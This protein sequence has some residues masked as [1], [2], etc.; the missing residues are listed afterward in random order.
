MFTLSG[1]VVVWGT[2][3]NLRPVN[4]PIASDAKNIVE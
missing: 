2:G 4:D 3:V 1:Q